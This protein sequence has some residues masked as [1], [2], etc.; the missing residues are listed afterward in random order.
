[1]AGPLD[2]IAE[3]LQALTDY[4][5]RRRRFFRAAAGRLRRRR[6]PC[7]LALLFLA[8]DDPVLVRLAAGP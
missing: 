7:R 4:F 3:N 5:V 6:S 8:H 2:S 1:M